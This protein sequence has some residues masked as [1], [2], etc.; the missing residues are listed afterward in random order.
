MD[1]DSLGTV[2]YA[3]A[4]QMATTAPEDDGPVWMVNFMRYKELADYGEA[5]DAGISGREADDRYAPVEVL[6]SIGADIAYFGDVVGPDGGADPEW[7]RIAVVRYPTRKSFIDMQ[8]RSDFKEKAVHKEAGME[9]TIIM[10]ALPVGPVV[11]E[12]DGSGVVRFVAIPASSDGADPT[13]GAHFEV[14]GT[15]IGDERRWDRLVIS[16][17]DRDEG[18]PDGSK[19]HRAPERLRRGR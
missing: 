9:L 8:S 4:G 15:V 3:Y 16:W 11:G 17:S 1:I 10:C 6:R 7:H 2:D 18:M 5:G 12:P 19:N 14:E 13:E